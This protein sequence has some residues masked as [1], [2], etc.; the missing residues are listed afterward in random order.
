MPRPS[1]VEILD[2]AILH[3][4]LLQNYDTYLVRDISSY[5]NSEVWPEVFAKL[6]KDLESMGLGKRG[7]PDSVNRAIQLQLELGMAGLAS[8]LN[9]HFQEFAAMEADWQVSVLSRPL[10]LRVNLNSPSPQVLRALVEGVAFEGDTI[11]GWFNSIAENAR[12]KISREVSL[13]MLN[14]SSVSEISRKIRG[15]KAFGYKDGIPGLTERNAESIARTAVSGI[16]ASVR[17]ETFKANEQV[18]KGVRWVSVL[19]S[20]T[21]LVCQSRDGKVYPVGKGPRPPAHWACRST[22]VA[23][24]KSW[25]DMGIDLQDAPEGTRASLNGQVPEDV[26]YPEWLKSQSAEVQ[27]IALGPSR[28][29]MFRSGKVKVERFVSDEGRPLTLKQI[30]RLEGIDR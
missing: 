13:G 5:L 20:R 23:V 24:L 17:E 29:K 2:R 1:N 18:I 30:R 6:E 9:Q 16:S 22:V 11:K 21:S 28:A 14:G 12:R 10:F 4:I 19:D 25:K 27:D 15:T 8:R 3:G 7:L 26:T